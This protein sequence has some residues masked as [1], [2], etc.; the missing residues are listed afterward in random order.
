MASEKLVKVDAEVGWW[1]LGAWE[2]GAPVARRVSQRGAREGGPVGGGE[3]GEVVG[4]LGAASRQR[5][6]GVQKPSD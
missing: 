5:R 2:D 6:A 4:R 1:D 3:G